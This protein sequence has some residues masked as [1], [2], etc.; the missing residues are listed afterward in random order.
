MWFLRLDAPGGEA[1]QIEGVGGTPVFS[2]DNRWIAFT[3]KT[4][5]S[6]PAP[7]PRSEFQRLIDERF[8]GRIFEWLSYRADGRGYLPDPTDPTATAPEELYVVARTGGPP[9]PLTRLGVNVSGVAWRPDSRALAFTADS[10]QRDEWIY[11]RADVW[12]VSLAPAR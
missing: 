4:P 7:K 3:R 2:P 12:Q 1:F 11:E 5:P 10:H 6:A 8:K 9:R